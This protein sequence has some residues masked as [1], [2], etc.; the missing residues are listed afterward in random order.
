LIEP[1][2]KE[3]IMNMMRG[4]FPVFLA[5]L[6]AAGVYGQSGGLKIT[7]QETNGELTITGS[8]GKAKVLVIPDKINGMSVTA[9]GAGAF[10]GRGL[11]SVTI[12]DSVTT[13]GEQA[14]SFNDISVLT[15][16]NNVTS[17]GQKA[18]YF[19]KLERLTLGESVADI[20][21]GAFAQNNLAEITIPPGVSSIGAY[22]FF[23]NRISVLNIPGS[24]GILGEGV[25]ST[26][27]IHTLIMENGVQKIGDGAFFNNQLTSIT[28]P[29]SV[30]DLGRRVFDSR[31][32][33]RSSQPPVDYINENGDILMTTAN[34]FDSFYNA[35]G[36]KPGKYSFS[37]GS[38]TFADQ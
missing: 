15:I 38:W 18:F 21:M 25:F 20:G 3:K 12:P 7:V 17:I 8:Q 11:S 2:Q 33:L 5:V 37:G 28:I 23:M 10:T 34:N 24:V 19:N 35:N 31:N 16:G 6:L 36:M 27:R 13:I 30:Q 26:N 14:F 4:F 22:A 32:T 29:G 1:F 9:I